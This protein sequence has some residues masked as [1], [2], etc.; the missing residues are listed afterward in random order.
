MLGTPLT[1]YVL[2]Q[3]SLHKEPPKNMMKMAFE[4]TYSHSQIKDNSWN[5]VWGTS[6]KSDSVN[7]LRKRIHRYRQL[8]FLRR[9]LKMS[10]PRADQFNESKVSFSYVDPLI[11][12]LII[13]YDG[14]Y[15]ERAFSTSKRI[16][17]VS[18]ASVNL[19]SPTNAGVTTSDVLFNRRFWFQTRRVVSV[20]CWALEVQPDQFHHANKG[21]KDY[22][23]EMA[24]AH[25]FSYG[26]FQTYH[27]A[28]FSAAADISRGVSN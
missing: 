13:I 8:N 18:E 20:F 25:I 19:R 15:A 27:H 5:G 21:E 6:E 2:R 26:S 10:H 14:S 17:R 7:P 16:Q 24:G 28:K 22:H 3:L 1:I 9:T 4:K 23:D 11:E 12:E